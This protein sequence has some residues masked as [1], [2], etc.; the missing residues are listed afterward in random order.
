MVMMRSFSQKNETPFTPAIPLLYALDEA[1]KI[2]REEGL[3]NRFRRHRICSEAFYDAIEAMDLKPFP[4]ETARSRT[5]ITFKKPEGINGEMLR[6]IMDEKYGVVIAGGAGRLRENTL[7]IG[8]MGTVSE[9]ETLLTVNALENA[10]IELGYNIED[11]SG[12]EA[13]RRRL[14]QQKKEP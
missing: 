10:L 1:L 2:I 13:A 7:R 11:G 9:M 5:V 12:I 4:E 8:C 14:H 3:N 6:K